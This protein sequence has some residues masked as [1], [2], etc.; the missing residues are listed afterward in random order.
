M[1]FEE[2]NLNRPLLTALNDL[3]FVNTTTIQQKVFSI[4]MSGRD[5]CG[6]AQTGTGKTFAYLLPILRRLPYSELKHPRILIVVPTRELVM[7]IIEEIKKLTTYVTIRY[8][9]IY[10]GTNINTQKQK[11][12]NGLDIL[13]ATPGRLVDI[14]NTG[15]LRL[16][17]AATFRRHSDS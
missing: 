17:Q 8:E 3:G 5:V 2:L 10:G 14:A 13:V 16:A 12:Y 9:G 7:Q 4:V 15:I 6:I 11:V 1:K